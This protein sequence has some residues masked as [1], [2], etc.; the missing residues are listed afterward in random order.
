MA[1]RFVVSFEALFAPLMCWSAYWFRPYGGSLLADAPKVSKKSC[2]LHPGLA[3]LDF[4]HS[5][6]AP[7][8]RSEGP[9]LAHRCSRGIHAAQPLPQRFHSAF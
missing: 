3:A 9:S 2:P 8:A 5:I 1:A 7:G 4:P 6:I